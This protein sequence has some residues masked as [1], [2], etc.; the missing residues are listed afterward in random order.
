MEEKLTGVS[1]AGLITFVSKGY[2]GW[3]SVKAI[4]SQIDLIYKLE[5]RR[6]RV[7]V[8]KGFLLDDICKQFF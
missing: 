3:S 1:P 5:P 2:G 7:M 4:F 6:D 8:N